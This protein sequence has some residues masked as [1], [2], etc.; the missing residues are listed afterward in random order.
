VNLH[1]SNRFVQALPGDPETGRHV[2]QVKA[3][4]TSRIDPEPLLNPK[5]IAWSTETADLL[6]LPVDS[7]SD[8][9]VRNVLSGNA[10]GPGSIPYASVYGGHQFGHWAGQ[11]G[12]GRAINLGEIGACTLQLKGAGRTPFSRHA[13]GRA[14]LRSSIREF[15]CSEA[16]HHL[17]IP[18]TRALSL[19]VSD[20][21]V[22]RDMF[23]DGNP[24]EERCAVV[25]RV[26]E[27]FL[28]F[29]HF[30]LPAA[31]ED[32]GLLK[33]LA[34]F[35][36][37]NHFPDI[38]AGAPDAVA[39]L[40]DSVCQRTANLIAQWMSVGFVHGVMNTDN[41]SILGECIDYGPY[42]WLEK[43]DLQWTPNT[44]DAEGRRYCYGN[45]PA[46]GQ[47]NL[48][49]LGNALYPLIWDVEPLQ[50]SLSAYN[51]AFH[52]QW[53]RLLAAKLGLPEEVLQAN[54]LC[55]QQLVHVLSA[56]EMDFNLFFDA[57][58][59]IAQ[60]GGDAGAPE[61]LPALSA[62][63]YHPQPDAGVLRD[64][65][66]LYQSLADEKPL[67]QRAAVMRAAN[68]V[69][70]LRNHLVQDVIDAAEAGDY[71]PLQEIF[72]RL[73]TPYAD[74]PDDAR[75]VRKCPPESMRRAGCSMLSCSS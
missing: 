34:D 20:T 60:R 42:G 41:M 37:R 38:N 61:S 11:L 4:M 13:D 50:A 46:I 15:L 48:A 62:C 63:S 7:E 49:R 66:H 26:S 40:F 30:E 65:L 36:L 68:P 24:Q 2:R 14:V 35:S 33:Q 59:R 39:Q 43:Y 74:S 53:N 47:W 45:Q 70:I 52:A 56:M 18:T 54:P 3:A 22:V 8:P 9:I 31:R 58:T 71:M 32:F 17:G 10:I 67:A 57:L 73:K 1:F 27:S 51:H 72:N 28:R 44:T 16:M 6:Q 29:G 21:T 5:L 25:C 69:F 23:Y 12:D 19:V 75:W 64:W 55:Y